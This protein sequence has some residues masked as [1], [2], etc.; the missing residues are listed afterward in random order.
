M[1]K[2][3]KISAYGLG[4]LVIAFLL[5]TT[6][7]VKT[8][9]IDLEILVRAAN[10][11]WAREPMYSLSDSLEHTKAPFVTLFFVP[12]AKLG[13]TWAGHLWDILTLVSFPLMLWF[14][15]E[16]F[17]TEREKRYPLFFLTLILLLNP[18]NTE[19]WTGQVNVLLWAAVLISAAEIPAWIAG[20]LLMFALSMKPP[21]LLFLPWIIRFAPMPK[22]L[23]LW[24]VLTGAASLL[25]Y[26]GIF[27][28]TALFADHV[29]WLRFLPLSSHKHLT[30][31]L[32][33]G[34]PSLLQDI[35]GSS[36]ACLLVGLIAAE[37][38]CRSIK[39]KYAAFA[40]VSVFAVVCSPMAWFQ[41]Y[42]ILAGF[43]ALVLKDLMEE[44]R[45]PLKLWLGLA[46]V[47]LLFSFPLHNP[48]VLRHTSWGRPLYTWNRVPLWGILIT[49][50]VWGSYRRLRDSRASEPQPV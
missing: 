20:F 5:A 10:H 37:L 9:R 27:G 40:V 4:W 36:P 50:A 43:V 15:V 38:S 1:K 29:E 39:D 11:L 14:L 17:E 16:K 42:T 28:S 22:R 48:E 49:L 34:L 23:G 25:L 8:D 32:N 47:A 26:A 13:L 44:Q 35:P 19:V 24:T 3:L 7:F 12:L 33:Y 6:V 31:G 30:Q 46:V 2:L 21:N 41:N 18:W 45:A